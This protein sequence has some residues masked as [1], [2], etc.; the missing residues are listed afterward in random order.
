MSHDAKW[1]QMSGFLV[2]IRFLLV[3]DGLALWSGT[4]SKTSIQVFLQGDIFDH[5]RLYITFKHYQQTTLA[6]VPWLTRTMVDHELSVCHFDLPGWP[7]V[8]DPKSIP[9]YLRDSILGSL[10][11]SQDLHRFSLVQTVCGWFRAFHTYAN[12]Y[13][14]WFWP[15]ANHKWASLIC[16]SGPINIVYTIVIYETIRPCYNKWGHT[17]WIQIILSIKTAYRAIWTWNRT[18]WISLTLGSN[19]RTKHT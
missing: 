5:K 6:E 12:R 17:G 1:P 10:T 8:N 3:Q 18:M 9:E 16:N 7:H 11:L 15:L 2:C 4:S 13:C 19:K 14:K